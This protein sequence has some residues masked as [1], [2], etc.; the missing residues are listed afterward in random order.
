MFITQGVLSKQTLFDPWTNLR[1]IMMTR[2]MAFM[3]CAAAV[4]VLSFGM[5]LQA[6]TE[7]EGE[8]ILNLRCMKCHDLNRVANAS[9][10]RQGWEGTVKRMIIIGASVSEAEKET[11]IDFLAR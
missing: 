9:K 3:V 10:D 5:T 4:A 11:L 2:L 1:R 8:R 6:E 7:E